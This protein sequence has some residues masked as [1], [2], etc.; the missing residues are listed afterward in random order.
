MEELTRRLDALERRNRWLTRTV[1][2]MGLAFVALVAVGWTSPDGTV[3]ATKFVLRDKD[4]KER[5]SLGTTDDGTTALK[6]LDADGEMRAVIHVAAGGKPSLGLYDAKGIRAKVCVDTDG[7]AGI[8]ILDAN[9]KTRAALGLLDDGSPHLLLKDA[10]GK[11][12]WEAP[13]K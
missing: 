1:M 8:E 7:S 2:L 12:T 4:G 6:F 10:E 9:G 3:E 13:Q 5:T 11:T